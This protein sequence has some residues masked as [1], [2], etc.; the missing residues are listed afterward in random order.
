MNRHY[1]CIII[2]G[3]A[4]GLLLASR[5]NLRK[6]GKA[7]LILESTGSCGTKLRMS[8]AGHCNFTHTGS[9][10]DMVSCYGGQ[11]KSIRKVLYRYS[12]RDF[13][14]YLADNGIPSVSQD[15]GR[16]FPESRRSQDICDLLT[17]R[18]EDNGFQIC[19]HSP[20]TGMDRT[21]ERWQVRLENAKPTGSA[22][23][24][25]FSASEGEFFYEADHLII[26][27]GGKSYPGTGSNGRMW[28][29]L[30]QDLGIA[31]SE[32]RPA[33]APIA[34][35]DYPF[36]SLSGLS[37]SDAELSITATGRKKAAIRGNLLLTHRN[38]SGS[39]A[40]NLCGDAYP[41]DT[42]HVNYLPG[43]SPEQVKDILTERF[44][45]PGSTPARILSEAFGL[46]KRFCEEMLRLHFSSRDGEIAKDPF[47]GISPKKL[48]AWLTDD[49]Y[50][51]DRLPDW[52]TAM[53]TKGGI[54]LSQIHLSTMEFKEH[55]NL[56]AIGETLDV[57]GRTGGYNLQFAFSS[58]SVCGEELER[59]LT[60]ASC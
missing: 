18:S 10:K 40:L 53:A 42:L 21:N 16:V 36:E 19:R 45:S 60:S 3:G 24:G 25:D 57:D 5:L 4:S 34:V 1:S 6:S 22:S 9:V 15:D 26:A 33:L 44:A 37:F 38:F 20:V 7:G 41:G 58:A 46:P 56:Y 27:T 48:A 2:G 17:Q 30:T 13:I 52:N 55:P 31:I 28:K 29:T 54:A 35:I 32:P 51:V 43:Y 59:R 49:T 47:Q 14:Q 23:D 12:N 39:A 8:G 50:T 11:G